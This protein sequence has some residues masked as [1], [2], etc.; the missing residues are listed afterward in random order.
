MAPADDEDQHDRGQRRVLVVGARRAGENVGGDVGGDEVDAPLAERRRTHAWPSGGRPAADLRG[1]RLLEHVRVRSSDA[2]LARGDGEPSTR[3]PREERRH[4]E[5]HLRG[6]CRRCAV[7]DAAAVVVGREAERR[8]LADRPRD[9]APP[10]ATTAS[11]R[12]AASTTAARAPR[13]SRA[14]ALRRT[15]RRLRSRAISPQSTHARTDLSIR[16]GIRVRAAFERR[17][18]AA[19]RRGASGSA[20]TS[21]ARRIASNGSPCGNPRPCS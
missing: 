20:C 4:L 12:L 6:R 16:F 7:D 9:G 14:R 11:V 21:S 10:R 3:I 8:E 5:D 15:R 13:S 18:R 19:G 2:A 1:R 17:A